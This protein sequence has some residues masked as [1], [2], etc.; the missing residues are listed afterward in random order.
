[1]EPLPKPVSEELQH[2]EQALG[3]ARFLLDAKRLEA[4]A[5]RAY[6]SMFHAANAALLAS[7]VD[8]PKTHAGVLNL[9]GRYLVRTGRVDRQFAEDLREASDLRLKSDYQTDFTVREGQVKLVVEKAEAFVEEV[10]RLI[11]RQRGVA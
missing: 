7:N 10:K 9:F 11:A 1:M 5:N 8:K 4:A 3:D 6:Y 2:A